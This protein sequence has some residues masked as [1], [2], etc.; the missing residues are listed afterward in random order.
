MEKLDYQ[1]CRKSFKTLRYR[2]YG[3]NSSGDKIDKYEA[4]ITFAADKTAPT[5]LGTEKISATQVKVKF[6]EPMKAFGSYI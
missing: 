1:S 2:C 6:S 4:T 5:I 3:V